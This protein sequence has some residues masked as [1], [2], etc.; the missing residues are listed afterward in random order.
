M[1]NPRLDKTPDGE[2]H[3]PSSSPQQDAWR[4]SY[5]D[6]MAI[7]EFRAVWLAHALSMIGGNLLNIATSILVFQLTDSPLAAGITIAVTFLPPIIAGPL[8]SGLADLFPRRQVMVVCDLL[9][10][11]LIV[12]IGI[13]GMPVWAIWTLLF[14]SVLPSLPFA[15]ARAAMLT[16]IVQGERYVASTAIIQLTAQ[17]GMLL[18][19]VAGGVIV[20][21]VGPHITVM[22][23]GAVFVMTALIVLFGVKARPA[24]AREEQGE[25]GGGFLTM[26]GGGAKLVFGDSK[27]RTLALMAWLAGLYMVPYG[28]ANP[29]AAEAGGG[30]AAAG[31]IMAGT[32]IGAFVGGLILTRLVPPPT[33]IRLLGP[34]A[35]MTSVPLLI[36]L[37]Q[38]PLWLM[39]TALALCGA[40]GSYQFVANAAFVLCVPKE[41]RALAFGLV[42]AGLQAAQGLGILAAG[43]FAEFFGTGAVVVSAGVL[44]IT[45]A[46]LLTLPWSR[47]SHEVTRKME[48]SE[49]AA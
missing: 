13:P 42:A 34:L 36:W 49:A 32:P 39:V 33:R 23:N 31:L 2:G 28:L 37:F 25:G 26:A 30:E 40:A 29:L 17:I 47:M 18:G 21:L 3:E 9:R 24:P 48:E 16:E 7:G 1:A 11:A 41:G 4:S 12:S 22:S 45:C 14:C 35:V 20:A 27:L 38:P 10:A 5:R 46:V 43:F 19:L 6:V 15:A 44:G 8:L